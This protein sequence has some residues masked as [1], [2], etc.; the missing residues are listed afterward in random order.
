M[1][2]RI[3]W[4][5]VVRQAWEIAGRRGHD[6][7]IM[8]LVLL[9]GPLAMIAAVA[10]TAEHLIVF[11]GVALLM[12]GVFYLGRHEQTRARPGQ[13]Q[14][15]QARPVEPAAAALPAA[16]LPLAGYGQDEEL[17]DKRPARRAAEDGK[18]ARK[19]PIRVVSQPA[20][21]GTPNPVRIRVGTPARTRRRP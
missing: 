11:A 21:P 18:H 3:G 4:P 13:I 2:A 7:L 17:T 9:L 1:S 10:W 5:A 8:L 16:T 19:V 6:L 14:P 20:E 15:R 12:W